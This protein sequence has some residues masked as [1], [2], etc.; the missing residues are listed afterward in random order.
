MHIH[1]NADLF[2]LAVKRNAAISVI[3]IGYKCYK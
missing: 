3:V 1:S 2:I